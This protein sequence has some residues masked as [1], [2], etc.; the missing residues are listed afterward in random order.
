MGGVGSVVLCLAFVIWTCA[1][2]YT[3]KAQVGYDLDEVDLLL[4]SLYC[5][6]VKINNVCISD[7]CIRV[8]AMLRYA[9]YVHVLLRYANDA[10]YFAPIHMLLQSDPL[11][12][13]R[14]L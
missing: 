3:Q 9:T 1:M 14:T 12:K 10:K 2:I 5:M 8:C 7:V 6:K 13:D 11:Y 4:G